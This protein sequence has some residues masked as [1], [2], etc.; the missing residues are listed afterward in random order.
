[1]NREN[2]S[3]G[4]LKIGFILA[5]IVVSLSLNWIFTPLAFMENNNTNKHPNNSNFIA[6][7]DDPTLDLPWENNLSHA[8]KV[9]TEQDKLILIHMHLQDK[10]VDY[11]EK[12]NVIGKNDTEFMMDVYFRLFVMGNETIKSILKKK[13]VLFRMPYPS[14]HEFN[15]IKLK[16]PVLLL[17]YNPS[18]KKILKH[19][20][21]NYT[22]FSPDYMGTSTK[23]AEKKDIENKTLNFSNWLELE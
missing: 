19:E 12:Y 6:I 10:T 5:L 11:N 23:N 13:F 2:N 20:S 15:G 16:E 17:I 22:T 8:V 14:N 7:G 3:D 9:S 21:V 4:L 18:S 1:M